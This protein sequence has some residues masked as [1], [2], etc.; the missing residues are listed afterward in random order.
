MERAEGPH[1]RRRHGQDT[2][3]GLG[4]DAPGTFGAQEEGRCVQEKDRDGW[5]GSRSTPRSAHL[6][7][8]FQGRQL[9]L[10]AGR[11]HLVVG[12]I[13]RSWKASLCPL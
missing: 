8:S 10:W 3:P 2:G 1:P 7:A 11:A 4:Q 6:E 9:P 12:R 5:T 13:V